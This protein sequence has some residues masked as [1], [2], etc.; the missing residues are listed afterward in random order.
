[1]RLKGLL[2]K[3]ERLGRVREDAFAVLS[4]QDAGCRAAHLQRQLHRP[5][6]R[7]V[8]H[9]P[10]TVTV[11]VSP[12]R[13]S[14][15]QR[16]AD[17]QLACH[18]AGTQGQGRIHRFD[19][20]MGQAL[21]RKRN[22]ESR[23]RET[24]HGGGLSLV[25][26]PKICLPDRKVVG[27]EALV[28]WHDAELGFVSPLEF[29]PLAEKLGLIGNIT[30]WV[31]ERS[32]Q[33]LARWPDRESSVA[34]NFSALDFLQESC[35]DTIQRAISAANVAPNR[36]VIELTESVLASNVELI[37]TRMRQIKDIGV[38]LS[39]DDF[40]TGYS[41]LSYLRQFPIDSLKIDAS[42]VRDL[43]AQA[44]AAAIACTIVALA[45]SLRLKTIAEGVEHEA[46]ASF[47]SEREVDEC[48]GYL[49]GKP[50]PP[51]E[52]IQLFQHAIAA[53]SESQ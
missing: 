8:M 39:L 46:Q 26:Q 43:P 19:E 12:A 5:V 29:I 16:L 24:L 15:S 45:K 36:L 42:F 4:V 17:A 11:G 33:E 31:L 44:D 20:D 21:A 9:F 1:L 35:I 40:G 13:G 37:K 48:Q 51:A 23:L 28:R 7:G 30:Q 6:A 53:N 41:S 34:V 3:G 47:L 10:F 22:L 50:M 25:L 32:L 52:F 14:L 49:F 27:A 18:Q 2:L 38:T